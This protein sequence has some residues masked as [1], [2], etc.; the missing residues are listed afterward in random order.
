MII[1]LNNIKKKKTFLNLATVLKRKRKKEY[2]NTKICKNSFLIN[3][4]YINYAN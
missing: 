3:Y 4:Y 2:H 1:D